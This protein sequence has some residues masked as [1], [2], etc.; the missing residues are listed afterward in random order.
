MATT[1]YLFHDIETKWRKRWEEAGLFSYDDSDDREKFYVLTMYPYPSGVLHM[2]HVLNYTLGDVVTRYKILRGYNVLSPMGWD[3][4]GLPAENAA[5]RTGEHPHSFTEKNIARMKEQMAKAGWGYDWSREV[6]TSSVDYYKWTQ[7]LFLKFYEKGLAVKKEAPV[8]WCTNCQ[9]V[10][11]NEQVLDGKCERCSTEVEQKNMSQW[12]FTMSTYAQ[13]LL[14]GHKKLKGSWPDSVLAMQ[15]EWI[16][17]SRGAMVNF[18]VA[19]T[20]DAIPVFTTRPDTLWGVTFMSIAPEHPLLKKLLQG[21]EQEEK[22]MK[23]ARAMTMQGT[24]EKERIEREKE[25]IY[26]G[27]HVVNPVN[28]EKVPL[29]VANF[30]L[31]TYG[32]GAVMAVPAHDQRDFEF[33]K[34]YELPIHPVIWPEEGLNASTMECAYEEPD[35]MM[36]SGPFTGEESNEAMP[37]II[38]WL[39]KEGHGKGTVNYRLRD[40]LISRQRYW[41][42]PIPVVYCDKCGTVPIPEAEL[43]VVLPRDVEFTEGGGNPLEKSESFVIAPCPKCGAPARRETDT[44]DTFVDSSWYFLRYCDP[45]NEKAVFDP[46]KVKRTMPVDQYI[47]GIE[48]ATMHLIYARFF[49]MVLHDLGL[50]D[51]E[52]PFTRLFTQGMVCKTA[53]Y[54]TTCK[55]LPEEKVEGGTKTSDCIEGGRCAECG[56]EV[57]AEMTKISKTKLNIVDP[58]S[59]FEKYGADTVRLY[60]LS[61]APPDRM[62]IWSELG[63]NGAWRM[64]SRF[65]SL[66]MDNIDNVSK[67]G[68][69]IPD[70]LDADNRALRRKTHQCIMNVTDAIEGGFHFNTAIARCNELFNMLR[71]VKENVHGA[72]LREALETAVRI[73]SPVLPH[74]AEEA[75]EKLGHSESIFRSGWPEA[76]SETAA[77]ETIEVPVQLNGRIKARIQV[78]PGLSREEMEKQVMKHPDVV[79]RMQDKEP[80]KVIVVPDKLVNI[81][82]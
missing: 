44:M 4:F 55:W 80:K 64:V 1:E 18:T 35:T 2:G 48:H 56:G 19:E 8:N 68:A 29:W 17:R 16:G 20:G 75:W 36:M 62:Q 74:F 40:W 14:D 26:T 34:K 27:F 23:A 24:S 50:I 57:Q 45:Q 43:P 38:D 52:E 12:F 73:L 42:A 28:Q 72:V 15:E 78:A 31:M 76:D 54:C 77:E 67:P 11:A 32:T 30:A 10:L 82:C 65:W 5:I 59:M 9:T 33:A 79:K 21:T 41:G 25:G 37:H 7:W 66:V 70:D 71:T 47:G 81:V 69:A 63:I 60:M 53:Y 61:D 46:E 58:E 6:A 39:E 51:F 49:T 3:S 13:R 22:V